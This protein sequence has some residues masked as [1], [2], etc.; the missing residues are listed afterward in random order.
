[1]N[2]M[3]FEL[4]REVTKIPVD[5]SCYIPSTILS[6]YNLMSKWLVSLGDN[7]ARYFVQLETPQPIGCITCVLS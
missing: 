6:V 4:L 5:V 1:M 7:T 2:R 3:H